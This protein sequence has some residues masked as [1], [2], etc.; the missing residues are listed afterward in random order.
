MLLTHKQLHYFQTFG[1]L[2]FRQLLSSTE[3]SL[4]SRQFNAGLDAWLDGVPYDGKT[5]HYAS[6]MESAS[7]FIAALADDPRFAEVSEQLLGKPTLGIV[8]DGNY[9]VGDT[10]WHPDT[11]SL[12]Y[13]GVKFC[14]YPDSL[15]AATG[16][17][18]VIPGSHR[19]SLHSS[20]DRD[21]ESA[22]GVPPE[23]LPAFV[24]ESEPGDVLA[25][26]VGLWHAAFGGSSG[27]RQGVIVYYENPNTPAATT[28]VIEQMRGNHKLYA[29]QGRALYGPQWRTV[30]NRRHQGWLQRLAE[31]DVL[32][33]LPPSTR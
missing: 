7:P 3:I 13:S 22:Y 20:I 25:F 23:T 12:D 21:V 17:L 30:E 31:L 6:L 18:R 28:A 5:R 16:A 29:E 1:F 11:F 33:T 8:V 4:Y 26:N 27:R 2:I 24:F 32:E 14:I 10:Q 15:T 9:M 19:E